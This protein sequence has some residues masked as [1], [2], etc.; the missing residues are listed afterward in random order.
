M[1]K[2]PVMIKPKPKVLSIV[3]FFCA[4]PCRQ[5]V[6]EKRCSIEV[7]FK[8]HLI[9]FIYL[10]IYILLRIIYSKEK[11]LKCDSKVS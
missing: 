6:Y 1:R 9:I 3:T 5:Q 7:R 2:V 8:L 10:I 4:Y 11:Y